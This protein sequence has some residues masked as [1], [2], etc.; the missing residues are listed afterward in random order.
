[1]SEGLNP[2]EPPKDDAQALDWGHSEDDFVDASQGTRLA[3]FLIDTVF[4]TF[5]TV[6]FAFVLEDAAWL[7]IFLA[8]GYYLVF[9]AVFSRTPAKWITKTRV[10]GVG[11]AKP[12]FT[13]ILGR[14]LSRFVPFEPFSFFFGPRGWHDS[15]SGTRVVKD[16]PALRT[17]V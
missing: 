17:R 14:T 15:W 13:Q 3:N 7:L 4:R 8:L 6:V 2:F 16:E 12:R 11:G 5:L 1:M 9:E 10:I